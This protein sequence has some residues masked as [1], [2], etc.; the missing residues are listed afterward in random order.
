MTRHEGW[1]SRPPA[2]LC[3]PA[4]FLG[5]GEPAQRNWYGCDNTREGDSA[6]RVSVD[7][8]VAG[9]RLV[10][11]ESKGPGGQPCQD[12]IA[13]RRRRHA[14]AGRIRG[15]ARGRMCRSV[16][17]AIRDCSDG[18]IWGP[19]RGLTCRSAFCAIWG[20]PYGAIG[21]PARFHVCRVPFCAAPG[22]PYGRTGG[23]AQ[24]DA[25]RSPNPARRRA[26]PC[27]LPRDASERCACNVDRCEAEPRSGIGAAAVAPENGT[28]RRAGLRGKESCR[29]TP[30]LR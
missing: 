7:K 13:G 27:F 5:R 23:P 25:C 17:F 18:A 4:L 2:T 3:V 15:P 22:V 28:F 30:G 16:F 14:G 6:A 20:V 10:L 19:A 1:C 11:D 24:D 8:R 9:K 29:K 26:G 21:G 12:E